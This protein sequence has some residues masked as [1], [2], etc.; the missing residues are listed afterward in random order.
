MFELLS[1][2]HPKEKQTTDK[3]K[4]NPNNCYSWPQTHHSISFFLSL[5]LPQLPQLRT[6]FLL[7]DSK[8][9]AF[10][11]YKHICVSD[12]ISAFTIQRLN[13]KMI[14]TPCKNALN[15]AQA[16]LLYHK[17]N[18]FTMESKLCVL[19]T[20]E[21][22]TVNLGGGA[23]RGCEFQSVSSHIES[24]CMCACDLFFRLH[25]TCTNSA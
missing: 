7:S 11:I 10:M 21:G 17:S 2:S 24:V 4:L 9:K 15:T 23:G 16:F 20:R 3:L 6:T 22:N 13:S 25:A 8:S 12:T 1:I 18:I 5:S 19:M 14:R